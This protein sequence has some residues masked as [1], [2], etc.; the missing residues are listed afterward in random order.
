MRASA[1]AG[2]LIGPHLQ[3]FFAEH[4]LTHKR[5]SPETI[6]SYR[7]TFR[8]LLRFIQGKTGTEPS[9]LPLAALDADAVLAFLDHLERDRG[10]SVRS[11]NNRLA[12]IRSFFRVVSLRVPDRL[13]Q[14]T[15][16][17]AIPIKRGDKRL[18]HYLSRDEVKALLAAPDQTIWSVRRDHALLL[19]LYNTGARVSEIIALRREQVRLDTAAA[20]VELLGKGRKERVVPIWAETAQVLRAWFRERG[21]DG[22]G[23]AFPA[24]RG[25]ALSRDGVDHLLR[26]AVATAVAACPTL[27][28]KKVLPH[29]LRHSTAMHLFQAGVDMAVIALWLGHE[30]LET[31]HVCVEADL[32]TKERALEKLAPM[33]GMPARYRADD[34]KGRPAATGRSCSA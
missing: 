19:T 28:A 1:D 21:D 25:R 3:A 16:V 9:A 20:H 10:C 7:D 23:V 32:A 30:S 13:G 6:A 14:V 5:A 17:M 22:N 4:L 31:T 24:A 29:V 11:R 2:G 27:G 18:V 26:R 34:Q 33:P 8:L 15:Q 12:A